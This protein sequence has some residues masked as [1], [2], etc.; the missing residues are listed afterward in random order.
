MRISGAN[1][2]TELQNNVIHLKHFVAMVPY[3][4][5]GRR[6]SGDCSERE[7]TSGTTDSK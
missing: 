1:D 3:A 6:V 2:A 4:C 5:I 7:E